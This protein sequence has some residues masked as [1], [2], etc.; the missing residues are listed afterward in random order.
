MHRSVP[1]P[2]FGIA[3]SLGWHVRTWD[4]LVPSLLGVAVPGDPV[5]VLIAGRLDERERRFVLAHEM[6]HMLCSHHSRLSLCWGEHAG[7]LAP[8]LSRRQEREAD[9]VAAEI[10]IPDTVIANHDVSELSEVCEVPGWVVSQRM[11]DMVER[12]VTSWSF[13]NGAG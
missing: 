5:V 10:L 2:V 8:W 12:R 6:A 3:R 11:R 7:D 9:R 4:D 1:V 13:W